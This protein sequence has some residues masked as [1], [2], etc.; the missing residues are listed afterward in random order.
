MDKMLRHIKLHV[1]MYFVP[2]LFA[3]LL[4]IGGIGVFVAKIPADKIQLGILHTLVIFAQ[5][6]SMHDDGD[7][8][9]KRKNS[10]KTDELIKLEGRRRKSEWKDIS[11]EIVWNFRTFEEGDSNKR[12][13]GKY[14][15]IP[16]PLVFLFNLEPTGETWQTDNCS[17]LKTK[18]HHWIIYTAMIVGI[19][20]FFNG[21][22][23][24]LKKVGY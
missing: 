8:K 19:L 1:A 24:E 18:L 10:K 9:E 14:F 20:S 6:M 7:K 21:F 3:F 15:V 12:D 5:K 17:F 11:D 13:Y 4:S 16:R 22:F 2:L 23:L